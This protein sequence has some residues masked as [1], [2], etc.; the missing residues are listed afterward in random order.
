MSFF[1]FVEINRTIRSSVRFAF[2]GAWHLGFRSSC[3]PGWGHST[4]LSFCRCIPSPPL[5]TTDRSHR[6]PTTNHT[7]VHQV[8]AQVITKY[9]SSCSILYTVCPSYSI[10]CTLFAMVSAVTHLGAHVSSP[11]QSLEIRHTDKNTKRKSLNAL[12]NW[13]YNAQA[14]MVSEFF[15]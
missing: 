7:T 13:K 8:T 5:Y 12:L 4:R 6:S 2:L 14:E 1:R 15:P 3:S 11:N 9:E 10:V